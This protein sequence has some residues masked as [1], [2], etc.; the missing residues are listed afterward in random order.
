MQ[1]GVCGFL[2]L[3]L[4]PVISLTARNTAELI[5]VEESRTKNVGRVYERVPSY[6]LHIYIWWNLPSLMKD[7]CGL[8]SCSLSCMPHP[9]W[10]LW[11]N[12]VQLG[13]RLSPNRCANIFTH[14]QTSWH[15]PSVAQHRE[16]R[17][18]GEFN[19]A[20]GHT[21]TWKIFA[22]FYNFFPLW[23]TEVPQDDLLPQFLK[24]GQKKKKKKSSNYA[25]VQHVKFFLTFY[26]EA[27]F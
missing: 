13:N 25:S 26:F 23:F 14:I 19:F 24:D 27:S 8:S 9:V 10:A 18:R 5:S 22:T 15:H 20:V 7:L 11:L 17:S 3:K 21:T 1:F 16:Y 4:P 6:I 2:C 12:L